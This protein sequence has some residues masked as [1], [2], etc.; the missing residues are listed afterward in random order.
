MCAFVVTLCS[1]FVVLLLLV[2]ASEDDIVKPSAGN[3]VVKIVAL[4]NENDDSAN[5]LAYNV[6]AKIVNIMDTVLPK[7]K[8]VPR[9][10]YVVNDMYNVTRVV[11]DSLK[12]GIAAFIDGTDDEDIANVVRSISTRTQ[13]PFIETHWKTFHRPPDPYAINIYP[14][15]SLLATAIRDIILDM[16][17]DSFTA[18]YESPESL[19][20]LKALLMHF[21]YGHKA[22]GKSIKIV[23]I[24]PTDDFR[25]CSRN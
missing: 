9:S 14:D 2:G 21:D 19:I 13:I 16:D 1:S 10:E 4:F 12:L 20:R 8:I 3:K 6:S 24:P 15:P 18:I 22:P 7:N 23:Q 17:W 25:P 11:C 5:Q